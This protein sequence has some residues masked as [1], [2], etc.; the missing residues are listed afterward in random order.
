MI[1]QQPTIAEAWER[2]RSSAEHRNQESRVRALFESQ[3]DGLTDTE[4]AS[5]MGIS[6]HGA[7]QVRK[8]LVES[9]EVA[10]TGRRKRGPTG[11]EVVVWGRYVEEL[12]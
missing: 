11:R 1:G 3:P 9:G 8:L 5:V 12:S 7:S 10:D 2:I 6:P 4:I